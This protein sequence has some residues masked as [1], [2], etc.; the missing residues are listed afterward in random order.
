MFVQT[1]FCPRSTLHLVLPTHCSTRTATANELKRVSQLLSNDGYPQHE[2]DEVI[3]R[4][5]L[6]ATLSKRLTAHLQDGALRRHSTINHRRNMTRKDIEANTTILHKEPDNARL[7]MRE[8]AYIHQNKSSINTQLLPDFSLPSL[9]SQ[10][11]K[12][13]DTRSGILLGRKV[14]VKRASLVEKPP[15]Q[16]QL[17]TRDPIKD[18]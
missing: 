17:T 8:A 14:D 10:G 11:T 1:L 7:R 6:Q 16:Q 15:F 18:A 12:S 4:P 13:R 3:R 9:R 5:S 2:I